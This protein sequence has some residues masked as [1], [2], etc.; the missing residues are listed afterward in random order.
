MASNLAG[1]VCIGELQACVLRLARLNSDCRPTGGTSG[2]IVTAG[3]VT[4]TADPVL[5]EA[6]EYEQ[7]NGCGALLFSFESEDKIKGYRLS[8]ELGF[9]DFEAMALMF[10]GDVLLGKN[11][12]DFS[13]EV[14]GYYDPVYTS[15][16]RSGI[17]LEVITT[18]I[19][20]GSGDCFTSSGSTPVAIGHIFGK[21]KLTPGQKTFAD[22][23]KRVTFTGQSRNNPNLY[24]GPWD[25]FPAAGYI[26]NSPHIEVGYSQDEYDAIL[27]VVQCGFVDLPT[28]S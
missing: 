26:P 11:T 4:L 15:P 22:E 27:D 18:A 1:G 14:I 6:K 24:D 7:E 17:Y 23:I 3:L 19:E 9:S 8:G 10:G 16:S 28:G 12:G 5:K 13:G 25:D 21:V 20:S 2:G